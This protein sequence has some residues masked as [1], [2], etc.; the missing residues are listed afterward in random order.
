MISCSCSTS[1]AIED[2][3]AHLTMPSAF[4]TAGGFCLDL[5]VAAVYDEPARRRTCRTLELIFGRVIE[6][7]E[8]ISPED[9]SD[10]SRSLDA[11]LAIFLFSFS[12]KWRTPEG[13]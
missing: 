5:G 12:S 9:L 8:S 3:L 1:P 2:A 13:H 7:L 10:I 11:R 6:L 4:A